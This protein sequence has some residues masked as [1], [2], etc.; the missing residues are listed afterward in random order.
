MTKYDIAPFDFIDDQHAQL[1]DLCQFVR[2]PSPLKK[3]RYRFNHF[4]VVVLR[5]MD[6]EPRH[7]DRV[8][9][10]DVISFLSEKASYPWPV[11]K[12]ETRETHGAVV[13]L[14][15][16]YAVKIKKAVCFAYMDFSTLEKRHAVC[17]QEFQLNS[18]S[19]PQIY[20]GVKPVTLER[21]GNLAIDGGGAVVEWCLIMNRFDEADVL[22]NRLH[23]GN[24]SLR[25]VVDLA[26]AVHA[27][28]DTAPIAHDSDVV[29]QLRKIVG[30]VSEVFDE[31]AALFSKERAK[32]FRLNAL[33]SLE[34]VGHRLQIREES[35]FVRR[36]HGDLHLG[37][38][39]M[40]DEKPVLFDALEFDEEL[41]TIDVFY[42]L[43]FLLMDMIAAGKTREANCLFN[44]YL[45]GCNKAS[46][47][48]GLMAMPLF[49]ALRASI[50]AMVLAERAEQMPAEKRCGSVDQAQRYFKL[51][52]DFLQPKAPSLIAVGGLSGTGKSTLAAQLAP[53]LGPAPGAVHLRSDVE[54]KIFAAVEETERLPER[55][56]SAEVTS[57][58]YSILGQKA[59]IILSSDYSVVVDAT[60]MNARERR[61][62]AAV[63]AALK[64]P[65]V[66]LWL[67]APDDVMK[68]R[69]AARCG[70]ASDATV[71]VVVKQLDRKTGP[72]SWD[73]VNAGGS[74]EETLKEALATVLSH[75]EVAATSAR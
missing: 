35:G 5:I 61:D 62:I 48:C 38:I 47:L 3:T 55:Y 67:S 4:M 43:A 1:I 34:Q 21:G 27:F 69:V 12:V 17:L 46:S 14:A 11:D 10:E 72:I 8:E 18:R 44:R 7:H 22:S 71:D 49:L 58:I 45:Y 75:K 13:F 59:E 50:R 57:M 52:E 16:A 73:I 9:Q 32:A 36:C 41:A 66:G 33:R 31:N 6:S 40:I 53:A 24:F 37:N 74:G 42:D 20:V 28:H 64:V 65:F 68:S 15:G 23:G 2:R 70:D 39:V 51:S 19:A 60:F 54:R 30:E 29:V 26:D 63:A 25:N 56:Y